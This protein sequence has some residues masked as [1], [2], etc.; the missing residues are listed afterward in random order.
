[1]KNITVTILT[2]AMLVILTACGGN[3]GTSGNI[4]GATGNVITTETTGDVPSEITEPKLDE[5]DIGLPVYTTNRNVTVFTEISNEYDNNGYVPE[6]YV[7]RFEE[8]PTIALTVKTN[9]DPHEN[10][11]SNTIVAIYVA[12]YKYECNINAFDRTSFRIVYT[13]DVICV[14]RPG[15]STPG[16]AVFVSKQGILAPDEFAGYCVFAEA[17]VENE[18]TCLRYTLEDQ[19][20]YAEMRQLTH[21][22]KGKNGGT[23]YRITGKIVLSD[24]KIT[25]AEES[26]MTL[27]EYYLTDEMEKFRNESGC[28]TFDEYKAKTERELILQSDSGFMY[29][30]MDKTFGEIEAEFVYDENL[31]YGGISDNGVQTIYVTNGGI[32][33]QLTYTVEDYRIE[34]SDT[35]E[36]S[37][38]AK[39]RTVTAYNFNTPVYPGVQ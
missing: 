6:K 5:N 27:A 34:G 33:Y 32:E 37:E 26:R 14:I 29:E 35:Y 19:T 38:K 11:V 9:I 30:L 25:M 39:P 28:T 36:F 1:M 21:W 18:S 8:A 10:K 17:D 2:I 20:L 15:A 12:D 4:T 7:V 16:D 13:D 24:N 3:N 23:V 31:R 22:A